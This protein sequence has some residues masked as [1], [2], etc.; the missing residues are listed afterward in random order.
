ML[1][2]QVVLVEPRYEG[3]IGFTARVLKNFGFK[4]LVLVKPPRLGEVAVAQAVHAR[5]VL[6]NAVIAS[7][8]DEA[9]R[10]SGI[11]VAAT[12]LVGTTESEHAR[13]PALSPLELRQRLASHSGR[14]S[15][16]L[17]REDRGLTR[18]E[19]SRCDMVVTIPTSPEYPSL[20]LSH[21]AAVLLYELSHILPG[22]IELAGRLETE[23]LYQHL[24]EILRLV[25][26]KPHKF[27]KTVLMLRRIL[28]RAVLTGREV[29][30]LRG[31]LRHIE[32][33]IKTERKERLDTKHQDR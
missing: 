16:V 31:V 32:R 8:L 14:I 6:E 11:S 17:G 3:N 22:E 24:E 33:T 26:Y 2:I 15:L 27:E 19:I 12:A 1:D 25:N 4:R 10:D 20:N 28:G 7:S 5:D 13:M 30:T 23:L 29:Q 21:A 18:S 9:I